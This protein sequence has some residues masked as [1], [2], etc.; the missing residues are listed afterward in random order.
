MRPR[1]RLCV[2]RRKMRVARLRLLDFNWNDGLVALWS[3]QLRSWEDAMLP[4]QSS[5]CNGT[6]WSAL[7]RYT[8]V[9]AKGM[10]VL[11]KRTA[12][13]QCCEQCCVFRAVVVVNSVPDSFANSVTRC[14]EYSVAN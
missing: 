6:F 7:F 2:T 11:V 8:C 4:L 13:A 1:P 5:F 14:C 3:V 12:I 9:S 10:R